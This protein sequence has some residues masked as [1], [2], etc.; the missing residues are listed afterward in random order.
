VESSRQTKHAFTLVELL[1]VIA[2]IAILAG[3]LIPALAQAK[4]KSQGTRCLN[5][6]KQLGLATL[7]YAGDYKDSVQIDFPLQPGVTWGTVLSTNRHLGNLDLFVCPIYAPKRFT[8]WVKIYG[9]R[10][11]A[12][13]EDLSGVFNEILKVD[14]IAQPVE[15]LHLADT[16]SRGRAGIG[17][18]Q[19]YNFRFDSEKQIHAR[20]SGKANGFFIDGHVET[21]NRPRLEGLGVSAL[22]G[23]DAIPSYF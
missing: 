19:Y 8:N 5:N 14:A 10:Q 4:A 16:T 13:R 15:Y 21:C 23:I 17:A 22:Y 3:L 1:V 9:V 12:P 18:E 11:D 2:I 20:H 7:M 6:L